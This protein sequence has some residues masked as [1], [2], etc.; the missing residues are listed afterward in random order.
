VCL[1]GGALGIIALQRSMGLLNVQGK[2]GM[3]PQRLP[4]LHE[5]WRVDVRWYFIVFRH[6]V[7]A[8]S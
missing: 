7:S 4:P 8:R 6:S 2:V 1:Q 5:W 3:L